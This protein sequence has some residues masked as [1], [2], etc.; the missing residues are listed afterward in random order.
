[1]PIQPFSSVRQPGESFTK[2][3]L[4]LPIPNNGIVLQEPQYPSATS[5]TLPVPAGSSTPSILPILNNVRHSTFLPHLA[6]GHPLVAPTITPYYSALP[7]ALGHPPQS[8]R[9]S[10]TLENIG[11]GIT[12]Q[13]NQQRLAAAAV[14]LP[15]H[16]SLPQCTIHRRCW[17][18]AISLLTLTPTFSINSILSNDGS[19]S[20]LLRIKVK[21]YPPQVCI[22]LCISLTHLN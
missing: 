14:N 4:P 18:L 20:S 10:S 22:P 6:S 9:V 3:I 1:M 8:T 11:S 21:V 19:S 17:G 7:G 5:T 16:V 15:S 12:S 2:S 13:V